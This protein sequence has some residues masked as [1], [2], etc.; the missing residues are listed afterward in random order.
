MGVVSRTPRAMVSALL[1]GG[2][3][4]SAAGAGAASAQTPFADPETEELFRSA[5]RAWRSVDESVVR[6][7]ALVQQRM[8]ASLRTPLKDRTIFSAE[9]AARIFWDRDYDQIEQILASSIDRKS[10]RLNSSHY[11]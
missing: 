11:S 8:A 4:W 6:Y 9:S 10:T 2:V 7:T 1:V 3:A 5:Q